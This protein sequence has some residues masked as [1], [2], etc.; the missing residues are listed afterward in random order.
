MA[1]T[2]PSNNWRFKKLGKDERIWTYIMIVMILMMG[3]MTIGFVFFG[4]QN[5]PE[6]YYQFDYDTTEYYGLANDGNEASG[7]TVANMANDQEAVSLLSGGEIFMLGRQWEWLA[8]IDDRLDIHGIQIKQGETYQ[9]HVGSVDV[10][11]GFQLIGSNFIIAIQIVPGYVYVIDFI[12]NET[13]LFRIICNEFCGAAHH[14]MAGF[15][16]VVE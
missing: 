1:I 5:P 14:Q 16:E 12:P 8:P 11:H 9:L 10:L 3:F 4:N 15:M 7:A 13:G 2:P 6:Q